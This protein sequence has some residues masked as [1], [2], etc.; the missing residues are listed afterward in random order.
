MA[1]DYAGPRR[2][3]ARAR[4]V[5]AGAEAFARNFDWLLLGAVAALVGYGLHLVAG[6]T[7][8]DVPGSS[9]YYVVRQAIYAAVGAVGMVGVSLLDP[10]VFRRYWRQSTR[11]ASCC[12]CS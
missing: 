6:I 11:S 8:D 3:R 7:R 9:D 4:R 1:V 10:E 12:S 5:E 2:A